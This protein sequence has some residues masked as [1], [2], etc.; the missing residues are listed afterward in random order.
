AGSISQAGSGYATLSLTSGA[1]IGG[2]GTIAG[3]ALALR[4]TTGI[5]AAGTPLPTAVSRLEAQTATGGVF[6]ANTGDLQIGGVDAGLAGVRVNGAGN[7]VIT[8]DRTL[9]ISLPGETIR[10]PGAIDVTTRGATAD[11]RTAGGNRG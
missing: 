6:V 7:V 8:N 3:T 2:T 11:L 9:S 5:G 1:A 4:A 10:A